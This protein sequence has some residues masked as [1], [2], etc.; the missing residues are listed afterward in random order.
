MLDDFTKDR[1]NIKWTAMM[2]PEHRVELNQLMESLDDV[3]PPELDEDRLSYIAGILSRAVMEGAPVRVRYW[4][5]KRNH[6]LDGVVK[7]I[8]PQI[9]AVLMQLD[10][11]DSEWV[12]AKYIVDVDF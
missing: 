1:G 2:L 9:K 4:K 12:P 11:D 8:D 7:R 5:N 10:Q 3:D 6:E